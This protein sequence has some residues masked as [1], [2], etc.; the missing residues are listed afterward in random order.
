MSSH[1]ILDAEGYDVLVYGKS[2]A[3]SPTTNNYSSLESVTQDVLISCLAALARS[4]I[5]PA[6]T[7]T[8]WSA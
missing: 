2:Q 4:D 1:H 8:L 5:I 3:R 7:C 6:K